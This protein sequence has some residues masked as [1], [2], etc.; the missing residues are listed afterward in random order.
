MTVAVAKTTVYIAI[1]LTALKK[2]GSATAAEVAVTL[3][4]KKSQWASGMGLSTARVAL[5]VS[6]KERRPTPKQNPAYEYTLTPLGEA[7]LRE[8]EKLMPLL[9]PLPVILSSIVIP[10]S[11]LEEQNRQA[12]QAHLL[13][14]EGAR[15]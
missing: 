14:K 8:A 9:E 13:G 3:D 12:L 6:V 15:P 4:D 2:L 5:L 7:F 10:E 11:S 1:A